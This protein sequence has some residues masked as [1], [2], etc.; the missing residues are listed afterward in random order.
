MAEDDDELQQRACRACGQTYDYPV[1]KSQA[2]RFYCA[3]CMELPPP[4]R[5]TF[6]QFNK[7]L[8][9]LTAAVQKLEQ[10]QGPGAR[11]SR[12]PSAAPEPEAST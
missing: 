4:V 5:A 2:T 12:P 9:A 1:L 7:R 3:S 8:K 10:R 6:E 11:P